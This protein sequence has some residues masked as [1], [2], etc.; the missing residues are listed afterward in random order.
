M[1][2]KLPVGPSKSFQWTVDGVK[3]SLVAPEGKKKGDAHEF[4]FEE[5]YADVT[6]M[7]VDGEKVH[8]EL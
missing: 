5:T 4:S 3:H 8:S 7:R 2:D 1:V 6:E